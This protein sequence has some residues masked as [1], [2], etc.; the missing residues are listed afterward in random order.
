MVSRWERDVD[1][2]PKHLVKRYRKLGR[3]TNGEIASVLRRRMRISIV[4]AADDYDVSRFQVIKMEGGDADAKQYVQ[5]L[6]DKYD[7][8]VAHARI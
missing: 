8:A 5:M 6:W 2:P 1:A 7:E 3:L 4:D